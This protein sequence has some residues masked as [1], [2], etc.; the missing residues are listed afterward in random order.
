M[1]SA[2]NNFSKTSPA[3]FSLGSHL[4][5]D[6]ISFTRS[7]ERNMLDVLGY[8]WYSDWSSGFDRYSP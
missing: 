6:M 5:I 3:P 8:F 2:F 7:T 4:S 1:I